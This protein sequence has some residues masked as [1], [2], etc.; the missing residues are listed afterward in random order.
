MAGRGVQNFLST[1]VEFNEDIKQ[2]ALILSL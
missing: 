1:F 2:N